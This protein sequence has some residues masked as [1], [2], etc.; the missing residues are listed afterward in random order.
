M[1]SKYRYRI[2]SDARGYVITSHIVYDGSGGP[3]EGE[4]RLLAAL[5]FF[6]T[7]ALPPVPIWFHSFPSALLYAE[8][9]TQ[10]KLSANIDG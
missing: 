5:Y 3:Q 8:R 6:H 4:G 10:P 7:Q 2:S 9:L 1:S